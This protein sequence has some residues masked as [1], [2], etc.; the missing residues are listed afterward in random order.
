MAYICD[1]PSL[2]YALGGIAQG[3]FSRESSAGPSPLKDT[4][5]FCSC[6]L[7]S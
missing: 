4:W 3:C 1:A 2:I 5:I 6:W 7:A